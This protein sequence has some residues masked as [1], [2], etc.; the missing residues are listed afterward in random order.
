MVEKSGVW[1]N[2]GLKVRGWKVWGWS[3]GLKCPPTR[4]TRQGLIQN[5]P[6]LG[7]V[8]NNFLVLGNYS[9]GT[10]P[11]NKRYPK[12]SYRNKKCPQNRFTRQGLI[13]NTPLL[14][15]VVNHFLVLGNYSQGKYLFP[16]R[17][18]PQYEVPQWELPKQEVPP[19]QGSPE[20]VWFKIHLCWE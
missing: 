6:L 5:T 15:I 1:I 11:P 14:G 12:E 10:F 8:L 9:R 3:L 20:E 13:Q 18:I 2:H 16:Q 7:I 17:K 4:F 19:K